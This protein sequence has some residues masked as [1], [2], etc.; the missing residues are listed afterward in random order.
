MFSP[1]ALH[2]GHGFEGP[3]IGRIQP[4]PPQRSQ[5]LPVGI[6][7]SDVEGKKIIAQKAA[8]YAAAS[9]SAVQ[10]IHIECDEPTQGHG[11]NGLKIVC[12]FVGNL[13][14]AD[15]DT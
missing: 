11:A 2:R 5:G 9:R 4:R 14:G 7:I 10:L 3:L 13:N 1:T 15:I 12:G 6:V 8:T